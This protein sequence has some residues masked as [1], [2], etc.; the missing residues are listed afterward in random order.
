MRKRKKPLPRLNEEEEEGYDDDVH[1]P[2]EG[3]DIIHYHHCN[4]ESET[5]ADGKPEKGRDSSTNASAMPQYN[6]V[7]GSLRI[8]SQGSSVPPQSAHLGGKESDR[9][10]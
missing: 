5:L 10:T 2:G 9:E 3:A 4:S 8:T 6:S 1:L 7:S